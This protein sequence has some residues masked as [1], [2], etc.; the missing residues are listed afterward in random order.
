MLE[1]SSELLKGTEEKKKTVEI[2]GEKSMWKNKIEIKRGV[3]SNKTMI[4]RKMTTVMII[5]TPSSFDSPHK[6]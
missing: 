3:T 4:L 5:W 6:N 1:V 2:K